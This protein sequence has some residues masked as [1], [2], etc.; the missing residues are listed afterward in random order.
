MEKG[1]T[2]SSETRSLDDTCLYSPKYMIHRV[3]WQSGLVAAANR[4]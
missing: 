4:M 2:R 3:K 1:V